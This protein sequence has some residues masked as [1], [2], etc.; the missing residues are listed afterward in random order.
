MDD[1]R[2]EG[3]STPSRLPAL[4]SHT[5]SLDWLIGWLID[6]IQSQYREEE[7]NS[8]SNYLLYIWSKD[9]TLLLLSSTCYPTSHSHSVH[10]QY[11]S[12]DR[13]ALISLAT[14]GRAQQKAVSKHL[15]KSSSRRHSTASATTRSAAHWTLPPLPLGKEDTGV[16]GWWWW[17]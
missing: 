15:P 8:A 1:D 10:R 11:T 3:I 17:W 12:T 14:N 4:A 13:A 7:H 2:W 9:P 6:C 5:H 16:M